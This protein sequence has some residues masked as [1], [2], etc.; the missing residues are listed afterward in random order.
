[1]IHPGPD[2]FARFLSSTVIVNHYLW[3][4]VEAAICAGGV[5]E[6]WCCR[7]FPAAL[8]HAGMSLPATRKGVV[9]T[10]AYL[11][12][13]IHPNQFYQYLLT[14]LQWAEESREIGIAVIAQTDKFINSRTIDLVPRFTGLIT[15]L[16]KCADSKIIAHIPRVL[17]DNPCFFLNNE[18]DIDPFISVVTAST[19]PK[20][21]LAFLDYFLLLFA[22]TTSHRGQE[23]LFRAFQGLYDRPDRRLISGLVSPQTYSFFGP[24]KLPLLIPALLDLGAKLTAWRDISQL[25]QTFLSFPADLLRL[26]WRPITS[27]MFPLFLTQPHA[28]AQPLQ[29]YLARLTSILDSETRSELLGNAISQMSGSSSWVIRSLT[30][31]TINALSMLL[32]AAELAALHFHI[33]GLLT[34]PVPGVIA[35][36]IVPLTRLRQVYNQRN[37]QDF[38]KEVIHMFTLIGSSLDSFV[39]SVWRESWPKFNIKIEVS[40][41]P[42]LSVSRPVTTRPEDSKP[43][44]MT[45][46]RGTS[47]L[48]TGWKRPRAVNSGAKTRKRS[49]PGAITEASS[50]PSRGMP[51]WRMAPHSPQ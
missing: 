3:H 13:V 34:D 44:H 43:S 42:K 10:L 14:M 31:P 49:L 8:L 2:L 4:L 46:I 12:E 45:P 19:D 5:Q 6:D 32:P 27:V 15:S 1:V 26:S 16:C 33:A 51:A 41:L 20:V 40:A 28:L 24:G 11:A 30:A 50:L 47:S 37:E 17:G 9:D 38:E 18:M 48:Q 29:A 36:T 21:K 23:A 7:S 22:R 25:S 35:S 39:L